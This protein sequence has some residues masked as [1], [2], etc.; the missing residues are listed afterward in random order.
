MLGENAITE[1]LS[2]VLH[3]AEKR[4]LSFGTDEG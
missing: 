2:A 3:Q 4:V 1:K